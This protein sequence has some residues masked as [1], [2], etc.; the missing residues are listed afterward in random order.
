MGYLRL[1]KTSGPGRLQ[2]QR[3]VKPRM[4]VMDADALV[5]LHEL[6]ATLASII[7]DGRGCHETMRQLD[8]IL[9]KLPSPVP[10]MLSPPKD[11]IVPLPRFGSVTED[12]PVSPIT[13]RAQL[14]PAP[15]FRYGPAALNGCDLGRG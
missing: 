13:M 6:K 15:E 10:Q 1:I 4:E 3:P 7:V 2:L 9:S 8:P 14:V 11:E 5:I 12:V